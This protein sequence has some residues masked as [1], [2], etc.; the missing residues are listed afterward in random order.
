MVKL[1]RNT[2]ADGGI[3]TDS[4]GRSHHVEATDRIAQITRKGRAQVGDTT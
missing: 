4:H 2:F 3:L 1:V